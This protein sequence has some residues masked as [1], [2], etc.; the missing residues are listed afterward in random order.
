MMLQRR[1]RRQLISWQ[2]SFT[3]CSNAAKPI[4]LWLPIIIKKSIATKWF[5][6]YNAEPLLWAFAWRLSPVS[7]LGAKRSI[8]YYS[9]RD[10]SQPLHFVQGFG[11][12]NHA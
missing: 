10:P 4:A 9:N 3:L 7:F 5:V 2:K 6:L 8:S 11:S 12:G 1:L